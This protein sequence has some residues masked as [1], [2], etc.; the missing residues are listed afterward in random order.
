MRKNTASQSIGCQMTTAAD[1]TDFT[2]TVT[3]YITGDNGTQGIGTV[4]SGICTH[5]GGGYHSYAPSQAETN[6]NHIAFQFRGTGAITSTVQLYTTSLDVHDTVRA[7]LSALPNANAAASG[8]L[9][10]SGTGSHQISTSSGQVL[11]QSGTG[12]GQI[13]LTSGVPKANV[14]QLNGGAQSLLDLK[15]F[16]DDGYDPSTNKVQGVVLVD[17]L[18]GHTPQ[19]GD[20]FARLGAPVGASVSADILT[21]LGYL[22]RLQAAGILRTSTSQAGGSTT[23]T[24]DSGA[25]S[26]NDA[27]VGAIIVQQGEARVCIDYVG[28]TKV[29][30]VDRAWASN[31]STTTYYLISP[32]AAG[33]TTGGTYIDMASQT[34]LGDV[35]SDLTTT[36]AEVSQVLADTNEL[37]TDWANGGRLDVILDAA[38][39]SAGSAATSAGSAYTTLTTTIDTKL[40]NIGAKTT[41]LPASPAAVGSAMTL[42]TD[43]IT[44]AS[45]SAAAANKVA[46]HVRRR[47]QANVEASSDGDTLSLKSGY[48]AIQQMQNS[49][50]T[51][52]AGKITVKKTN[53][54][55]LGTLTLSTDAGAEPVDGVS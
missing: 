39:S 53:G 40:N 30:T 6:Y 55:S 48:G 10:T 8:G 28:S 29:A 7:G 47:T 41:N 9:L 54:D 27:Y 50:T 20:N 13:D 18:S 42:G 45:V 1:G 2:G 26:V 34:D 33:L 38:N 19:T 24:L 35:A 3:V 4:G 43:A 12:T 32:Q 31:P 51:D 14:V 25:S 16:A 46:D 52:E 23:I 5:E 17:T 22:T 44:A 36:K 11:V 49:N 37:Q 15:D 21:A